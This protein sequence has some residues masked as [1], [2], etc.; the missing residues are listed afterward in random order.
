[1]KRTLLYDSA[2]KRV[3]KDK[4]LEGNNWKIHS[5]LSAEFS[6]WLNTNAD[7]NTPQRCW[8]ASLWLMYNIV[9]F[10]RW[11]NTHDPVVN[12]C[13][14]KEAKSAIFRVIISWNKMTDSQSLLGLCE[15][16][17]DLMTFYLFENFNKKLWLLK[18]IVYS[19]RIQTHSRCC[20]NRMAVMHQDQKCFGS[21][22]YIVCCFISNHPD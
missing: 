17:Y 14:L 9:A 7:S 21:A 19:P 12:W 20:S 1:M 10:L 8:L 11:I 18:D 5:Q 6:Q 22:K 4:R 15:R 2:D 13:K 16:L 3:E